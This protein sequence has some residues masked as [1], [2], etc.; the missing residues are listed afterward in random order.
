LIGRSAALRI[1]PER[2]KDFAHTR[3]IKLFEKVRNV[4]EGDSL[5]PSGSNGG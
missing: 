5:D 3:Y 2:I 1:N 4:A